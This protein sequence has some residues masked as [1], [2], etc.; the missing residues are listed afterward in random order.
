MGD[1]GHLRRLM[2]FAGSGTT[3]GKTDGKPE[4]EG[5]REREETHATL[6]RINDVPF[7]SCSAFSRRKDAGPTS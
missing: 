1:R 5:Q 4:R 2:A 6:L 7:A 3:G